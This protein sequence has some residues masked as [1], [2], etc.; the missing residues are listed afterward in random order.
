MSCHTAGDWN[1]ARGR[2]YQED[3]TQK[4]NVF[5]NEDLVVGETHE[6]E[7]FS[8]VTSSPT[9]KLATLRCLEKTFQLKAN[10]E[11]NTLKDCYKAM[12]MLQVPTKTKK[13][14][15]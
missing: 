13:A 10:C 7:L 3:S 14:S 5:P 2:R 12:V 8:G 6:F 1:P 15:S 4:N 11:K 9:R